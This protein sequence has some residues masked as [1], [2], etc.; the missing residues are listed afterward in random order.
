[1]KQNYLTIIF[2][3][4][5]TLLSV[6]VNA[7]TRINGSKVAGKVLDETRKPLDFATVSLL[8]ASDSTL[9]RTAVSGLDGTFVF[10][11]L[12]NGTYRVSISMVGYE[13]TRTSEFT[14]NEVTTG[15]DLGEISVKR[16]NKMLGE[17]T[18]RA[19]KPFIERK[20]DRLVVN[21]EGSSVATGS[22]AL[23]VLQR[24]PGITLD[25][26]DN[27]AMQGKQGVLVMLDGKQ[28]YMSSADVANMLRNMPSSQIE[29]IELITN[30]SAKYDAA[31]NS[32]I[33]NIKTKK[34]NN[35]GTNGTLTAGAG[36]GDNYR[37][38]G[39]LSLNHRNK[40]I[41]LF[42]NYNYSTREQG[43][44]MIIDRIVSTS[45]VTTYF[46]QKGNFIRDNDNNNFKAGLDIFIDKKNTLGFL[47]N[48]YLNSGSEVYNNTTLIGRSFSQTDSSVIAIN[49]ANS[50]YR[51]MAYNANYKTILDTSGKEL[52]I[53][54]DYSRYNGNENTLYDNRFQNT[55]GSVTAPS[56]IQ[57]NTPSIIN[58]KAVKLDYSMPFSKT[59]KMEAG[60]KSSWVKTDND[61]QFERLISNSWQNDPG[62]SNQFIYDENVNAAY[63]N[64]NK[65]YKSTSVQLGLR[66]EQT[67]SNGNSITTAK[68]VNR[69]YVD[70]FP[71]VFI[72]QNLSKNHDLGVSYSRRIDRPSYDALNPFMFFLDQYTY[73]QG[74][75]FL[76]PQYTNN[77]ELSY[78]YKKTYSLTL[79]Y[80]LTRDVIT[81]VLL[82]DTA[83]KALFQTNENLDKQINYS[84]NLNAPVSFTKWW[85]TSN[86]ASVFY[87]GFRSPDLRG[88]DLSS[89]RVALQF[90]SQHKFVISSTITGEL[91]GDYTS[92]IEY[93]TL[94]ISSQYGLDLGL[95]KSFMKKK[96]NVK[97]ALSDIFDTR[98]QKIS[99]AYEGL[100]YNLVQKN[101]TR[102]A[103]VT[104]TYRFGK[105]EIKPERR[106]STG[107]EA[108]Q[109]RIKN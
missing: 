69:S 103:R 109:S 36:M 33:I 27:I 93:G 30:P 82:P 29:T 40:N 106:R 70:L 46:G 60:L 63:L 77:F 62:R 101:E 59:V 15:K 68:E 9:V 67:N 38:N 28:T 44:N 25:Q 94:K 1:M 43:Q 18:V 14:I 57:N 48:G 52:S 85:S 11:N 64:L 65:Q 4:I 6:T 37:G 102:I 2:I 96:A 23:E 16:D 78:N 5:S 79:N 13:K 80:S 3:L 73:N 100:D 56:F 86:N 31:G 92:P 74:N 87:L 58:I 47:V 35:V 50:R 83:K 17:V 55:N 66:A 26:N 81:Q 71:S 90:N 107:L 51:S 8:K 32:G 54:L 21:V 61:F 108:E 10:E 24:A 39:G 104:F 72:N 34:S 98:R 19:V 7:Q 99:S 41:N 88:Q 53:D 49:D 75:P 84:V 76:N 97:L 12:I 89:G 22:T 95:S 20:I 42:G 105:S 45:K 91:N